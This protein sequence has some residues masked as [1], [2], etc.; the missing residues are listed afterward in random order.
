MPI[1]IKIGFKDPSVRAS[2]RLVRLDVEDPEG[3]AVPHYRKFSRLT[4]SRVESSIDFAFNDLP[5][6]WTLRVTD[7]A[8]GVSETGWIVLVN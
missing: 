8:T 7:V 5:G 4:G 6:R 2:D 3:K 1:Q